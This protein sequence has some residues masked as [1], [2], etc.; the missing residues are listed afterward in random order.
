MGIAKCTDGLKA[1]SWLLY[2]YFHNS[3]WLVLLLSL[4]GEEIVVQGIGKS[5]HLG[6]DLSS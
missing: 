3:V 5:H 4:L 2:L 1:L 6:P